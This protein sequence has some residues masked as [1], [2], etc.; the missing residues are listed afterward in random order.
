[1]NSSPQDLIRFY[2]K[3]ETMENFIK[4]SKN[5]FHMDSMS[6]HNMTVNAN[7]L[8]IS[9]LAYNLFNWFK[10]WLCLTG[11]ESSGQIRSI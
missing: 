10:R 6:S 4:E 8:Q 2:C 7:R 3:R 11:S 1:M 9:V 5:S